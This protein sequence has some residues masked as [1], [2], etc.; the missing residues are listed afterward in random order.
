MTTELENLRLREIGETA[1]KIRMNK[2]KGD[3]SE[4]DLVF[5]N[6]E[7][8]GCQGTGKVK[9][10]LERFPYDV[11]SKPDQKSKAFFADEVRRNGDFLQFYRNEEIIFEMGMRKRS[12]PLYCKLYHVCGGPCDECNAPRD[13]KY[14]DL[15]SD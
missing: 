8:Y 3:A 2:L 7:T 11:K 12:E 15:E 13:T 4:W 9:V 14:A 1:K 5:R 6:F 10:Y